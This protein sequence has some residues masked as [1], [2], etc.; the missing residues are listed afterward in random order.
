MRPLND[1]TVL[2]AED[3]RAL[4]SVLRVVL[5][6]AGATVFDADNGAQALRI[7]ELHPEVEAILTD[8][9]M[10]VMDGYELACAAADL[11][12]GL[13]VMAC[14]ALDAELIPTAQRALFDRVAAKPFIPSTL[15]ANIAELCTGARDRRLAARL[16]A[17]C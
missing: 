8:L 17:A 12:P 7:L 13:P 9:Q 10:P 4:R 3:E 15:V 1:T 11:R 16:G 6:A 5:E 14:T 2:V